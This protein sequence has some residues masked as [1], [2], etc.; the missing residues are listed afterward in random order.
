MPLLKKNLTSYPFLKHLPSDFDELKE[1]ETKKKLFYLITI[2]IIYK[3]NSLIL[4]D[5]EMIIN[6]EKNLTELI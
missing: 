3:S 4:E 1:V 5:R 2:P 6:I